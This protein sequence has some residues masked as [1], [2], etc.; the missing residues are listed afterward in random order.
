MGATG[1]LDMYQDGRPWWIA[2]GLLLALGVLYCR[3]PRRF[4]HLYLAAETAL[5]IG[6]M[7][8]NPKSDFVFLCFT[9]STHIISFSPQR[10]G[11]LGL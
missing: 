9:L 3:W 4:I 5:V 7:I 11:A 1:L 6:L 8:L 10:T 2:A